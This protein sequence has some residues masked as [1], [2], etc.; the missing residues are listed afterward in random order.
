MYSFGVL[1][2]EMATRR[3]PFEGLSIQEI[4][5]RV[6]K[7]F[8]YDE[9][10]YQ[11]DGIDEEKQRVR[12]HRRNP[13]KAR[14]PDLALAEGNCPPALIDLTARCWADEA[15]TRPGFSDVLL[16][17]GTQRGTSSKRAAPASLP[18]APSHLCHPKRR[19]IQPTLVDEPSYTIGEDHVARQG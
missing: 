10:L 17:R 4:H 12:W 5:K 8:E 18:A 13:L 2:F 9:D 1:C 6:L 11:E 15:A 7:H 19:K 3:M 16:R 14:R